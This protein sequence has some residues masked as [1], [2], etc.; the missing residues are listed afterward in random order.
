MKEM[1]DN[2]TSI[3]MGLRGNLSGTRNLELNRKLG[4]EQEAKNK[5]GSWKQ[6]EKVGK[7][8]MV[9]KGR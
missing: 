2:K 8:R 6:N 3:T 7:R 1:T 4:I 9:Q 5:T